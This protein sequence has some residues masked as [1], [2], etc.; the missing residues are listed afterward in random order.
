MAFSAKKMQ[1]MT[2]KSAS[3]YAVGTTT[4]VAGTV[5]D[6]EDEGA[7]ALA[8]LDTGDRVDVTALVK[9]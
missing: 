6:V 9:E 4:N 3:G 5:V 7:R 2:G 1:A 8:V